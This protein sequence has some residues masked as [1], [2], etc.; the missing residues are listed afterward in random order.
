[1]LEYCEVDGCGATKRAA[2]Q[3]G[4]IWKVSTTKAEDRIALSRHTLKMCQRLGAPAGPFTSKAKIVDE[5]LAM[6]DRIARD[7]PKAANA[8]EELAAQWRELRVPA[9][10]R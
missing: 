5:E 8:V 4:G 10:H 9:G 6:L 1:M 7:H 2:F 3:A